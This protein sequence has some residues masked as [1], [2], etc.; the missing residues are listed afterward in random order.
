MEHAGTSRVCNVISGFFFIFL[1]AINFDCRRPSN[2]FDFQVADAKRPDPI[3]VQLKCALY[4]ILRFE[5]D[6]AVCKI[7][8]LCVCATERQAI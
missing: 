6:W 8:A 1:L 7:C 3:L 5:F 4:E 2:I